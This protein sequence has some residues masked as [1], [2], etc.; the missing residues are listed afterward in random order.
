MAV[1]AGGELLV[2][3][4]VLAGD[5]SFG[6]PVKKKNEPNLVRNQCIFFNQKHVSNN[7]IS[8]CISKRSTIILQLI[9]TL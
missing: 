8:L 6:K 3:G 4:L 5:E 9:M 2:V 7:S 1:L